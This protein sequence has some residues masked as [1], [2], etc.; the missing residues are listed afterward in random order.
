MTLSFAKTSVYILLGIFWL[1]FL[2]C[3]VLRVPYP[4]E[5]EWLEGELMC[6]VVRILEG[7]SIYLPPSA[8]FVSE[9][10]PPFFY[11]A[12]AA[13]CKLFGVNLVAQRL[14]SLVSCCLIL[15]MLYR[16]PVREGGKRSAGFLSS[17]LFISCYHLHGPWYD[18]GR[19]DML[20][21]ML[22]I[23][24]CFVVA[25]YH[26]SALALACSVLLF[27]L[28]CYT[29]Q[30][31]LVY[32]PFVALYLLTIS[33][34]R[35]VMFVALFIT[36]ILTVFFILNASTDG[37]FGRFTFFNLLGYKQH[38]AVVLPNAYYELFQGAREKLLREVRYEIFYK[39]PIFFTIILFFLIY[40][41]VSQKKLRDFNVW[42]YT[43]IPAAI[44]YFIVRPN[45]G[46]EKNDLIFLTLWGCVILGMLPS[47][48]AS[49]TERKTAHYMQTTVYF[50][51]A[52]QLC[53]QLY[54]P[55]QDIPSPGSTQKG[56]EFI[57]TVTHMN[58]EVYIP[59]HAYYAVMSGK[60]MT[61]NSG[62]FWGYQILSSQGY[63]PDDLIEKIS[64]QY[65]TAII[66]DDTSYYT[67]LGQRI[68]FDNI[69][70]LLSSDEPLAKAINQN[71]MVGSRI[72]YSTVD[73]FRSSTGFM[74]RPELILVPR[75]PDAVP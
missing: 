63:K 23:S 30:T 34:K 38:M 43:A 74:T 36:V 54:D 47:K 5:L 35:A 16:I 37:W 71:Y 53:L 64:H 4:F 51:L 45:L 28:A 73:E 61:F 55:R 75:T 11:I 62:A 9:I 46:S 26:H 65:F 52:L 18:L 24:G 7:K 49:F 32:V 6:H 1:L 3:L 58:G 27:T 14:V 13:S 60:Q 25:Y 72:S 15:Y 19:V 50:L 69:K 40:R 41:F 20:F 42:E 44:T 17:S 48:L 67:L 39:L 59:Y 66:I 57:D 21:F 12:A 2:Y 29:K 68:A 10:Y 22:L 31:G 8:E 33:K 56:K 70:L